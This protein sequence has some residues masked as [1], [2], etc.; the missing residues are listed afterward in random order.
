MNEWIDTALHFEELIQCFRI[1]LALILGAIIGFER[2]L[3]GRPAGLRTHMLV[4]AASSLAVLVSINAFDSGDPARL[5]SQVITGIGFIGAGAIIRG[6]NSIIGITTAST[7]FVCAIIGL[8]SGSGYYFAAILTTLLALVVLTC[9][10][11]IENRLSRN[12][13]YNS[14]LDLTLRYQEDTME[15]LKSFLNKSNVNIA[16]L[17]YK[18]MI[19]ENEKVIKINVSFQ[20]KTNMENF[21]EFVAS[22]NRELQPLQCKISTDAL[23]NKRLI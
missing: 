4:C 20:E 15:K 3:Y 14:I 19:L 22:I 23:V 18:E 1:L 9:F 2:E 12:R 8:A 5:A 13:K 11:K 16:S 17:E 6:D 10:V 21:N 7:I